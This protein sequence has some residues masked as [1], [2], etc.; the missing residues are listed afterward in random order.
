MATPSI[1]EAINV[2]DLFEIIPEFEG[3][4]GKLDGFIAAVEQVLSLIQGEVRSH[5]R[6]NS[7]QSSKEQDSR[8]NGQGLRVRRRRAELE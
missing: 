5:G 3:E 4:G 2:T 6:S 7:A 1:L 8:S